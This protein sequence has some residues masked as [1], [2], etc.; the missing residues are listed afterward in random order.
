MRTGRRLSSWIF[1]IVLL[2]ALL[3]GCGPTPTQPP[4]VQPT[5]APA[6]EVPVIKI[7]AL[8]PVSGDAAATGQEMR[9]ALTFAI[10]EIN[11]QGGIKSL[12]GAK[13]QLVFGDTQTKPDVGVSE[14]ERLVEQEGVVLIVGA[15][16]SS[17]TKP[18]TQAAERLQTP[19]LVDMAASDEITERGF[20]WTFRICPK[21]SW[22]ARD[23]VDFV[24]YLDS[25]LGFKVKR[26]ALLHEDTDWGMSVA[27]GQ[28][29]YLAEAGYE[30][31]IDVAYP[32]SAADLST[33]VMKVKEAQP[34]IVLTCTYLNDAVLIAKEREK[35]GMLNI[36][37]VDAAG[38]TIVTGFI[39]RLGAT[40]EGLMSVLEFSKYAPGAP[41]EVNARF[42]AKYGKDLTGNSAHSY[43]AGWVVADV[44]ERAASTDKE[45]IRQA[46]AQTR[47]PHSEKMILPASELY[48]DEQGQNPNARMYIVQV[49]NGELVPV[50]P[51]AYAAAQVKLP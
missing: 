8:H 7:G 30:M 35:L 2:A 20:K 10:D 48:F 44:L 41:S 40:A 33:Q 21:S 12:G 23:Q 11:A 32:T 43:V 22:Y 25:E 38:G 15:Y 4:T 37:F 17:V 42:A 18:A 9:E 13:I 3:G 39:E 19:F 45:A 50:W 6:K 26:V 29:K 31:V 24:R 46:L 34:D 51:T 47:M 27:E 14:V 36:P 1:T 49:Q 5:Q 16:N 28:K